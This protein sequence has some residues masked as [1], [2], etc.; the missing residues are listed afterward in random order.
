MAAQTSMQPRLQYLDTLRLGLTL[1]VNV[2]HTLI[3][4]GG[5]G[6]WF[7]IEPND[8]SRWSVVATV[9]TV[10]NQFY[11]MGL[12]FL[13]AGY[14]TPG[15][16]DRKG[17]RRFLWD[18]CVRLGIPLVLALF[19]AC[20]FLELMKSRSLGHTTSGY[21]NELLW[22]L[23]EGELSPGPLW[24]VETLLGFSVLYAIGRAAV[25]RW[26]PDVASSPTRAKAEVGQRELV[27][28]A[29]G[30][31][32]VS[33]AIRVFLPI[34]QEV[35]HLQLGF[36]GQ[37]AILFAV[38]VWGA[39]RDLFTHLPSG[40]LKTWTPGAVVA[41]VA[42]LLFAAISGGLS[43]EGA[44]RLTGGLQWRAAI[45]VTLES[46]YC[47]GAIVTLLVLCRD[48]VRAPALTGTFAPD[49]YAVYVLHAPVLVSITMAMRPWT[50][51]PPAKALIAATAAIVACFAVSH[52]L[53]R[54]AVVRRVL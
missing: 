41:F 23:R 24:F 48:R 42:L 16:F 1:L 27:L 14:F 18:R 49:A 32:A 51:P 34:G 13:I 9:V 2:H 5:A 17:L 19:F 7:H 12:F 47:V 45:A 20:P 50:A 46:I 21:W 31:A 52:A 4:Y 3:T 36:F 15:A 10:A 6:S 8:W 26:R 38:G 53:R 39:R 37:Y 11:F 25:E 54:V 29:L 43:P 22:R 35:A 40:L 33:F 44:R 30:I 28:L